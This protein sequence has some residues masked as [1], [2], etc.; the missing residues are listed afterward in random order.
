MIPFHQKSL[1]ISSCILSRY[2]LICNPTIIPISSH[3]IPL[4]PIDYLLV[5]NTI[6]VVY[7]L[8]IIPL[9]KMI[10]SLVILGA[11]D[12]GLCGQFSRCFLAHDMGFMYRFC[13][14]FFTHDMGVMRR[15]NGQVFFHFIDRWHGNKWS[16]LHMT[17]DFQEDTDVQDGKWQVNSFKFL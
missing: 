3:Y 15:P 16:N 11:D 14:V 5:L 4:Y 13:Y 17:W 2:L 10:I 1:N 9:V 6:I 12:T 7:P 8:M